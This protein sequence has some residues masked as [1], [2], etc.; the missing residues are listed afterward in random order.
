MYE[1]FE[2]ITETDAS[3]SAVE[4]YSYD[5]SEIK[6]NAVAV[7]FPKN[8]DDVQKILS[9]AERNKTVIT[10]RGGGTSLTGASVPFDSIVVD[11]SKMNKIEEVNVRDKTAVVQA[12]VTIFQ[13]NKDI[14]KYNLEFPVKPGSHKSCTIGGAVATN[15]AGMRAVKYGK[16]SDWVKRAEIIYPGRGAVWSDEKAISGS[17]GVLGVI[18]K[19]ELKLAEKKNPKSLSVLKFEDYES[20]MEKVNEIKDRVMSAEFM[21]K[22]VASMMNLGSKIILT[23]EYEGDEGEI[24]ELDEIKELE[25]IRDGVYP[26]VSSNGYFIIDDPKL[27]LDKMPAFLNEVEKIGIPCFGHVAYGVV[28]PCYDKPELR[29]EVMNLVKKY[30]GEISGEHGIGVVKIGHDEKTELKRL[31]NRHDKHNIMNRGKIWKTKNV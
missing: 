24:K 20:M 31:K 28:H 1:K 12:G 11:L 30:G 27:T 25:N 29:E 4:V 14:E 8:S 15:A 26:T 16:M 6:G 7:L 17:E 9:T 18:T 23:L 3:K 10:P 19:I 21:N 5:S 2:R 13:L 22:K